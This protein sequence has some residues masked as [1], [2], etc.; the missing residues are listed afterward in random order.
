MARSRKPAAVRSVKDIA[1]VIRRMTLDQKVGQ[2]MT[3]AW[4]G[5]LVDDK[6]AGFQAGADSPAPV[7]LA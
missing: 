7:T 4:Y 5:T 1:K 6:V 3:M 2:C